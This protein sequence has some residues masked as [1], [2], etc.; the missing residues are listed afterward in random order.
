M[1]T[2]SRSETIFSYHG[3]DYFLIFCNFAVEIKSQN[4]W[5]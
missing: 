3:T 2:F 4:V 1:T 5:I